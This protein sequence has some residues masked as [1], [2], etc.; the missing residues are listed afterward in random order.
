M[1]TAMLSV[2]IFICAPAYSA[3]DP[4]AKSVQQ[5]MDMARESVVVI[6]Q[7]ARDG[8]RE[9]IGTGFVISE[10]G[11]VA[12]SLHVIG[13]ARPIT[14]TFADGKTAAVTQVHAWDRKLDLA[15]IR[16][17]ATE[18]RAL[19]LGDSDKLKQG[20]SV[21]A[22]GNPQGL[23]HSVVQGVVS[24]LRE[25]EFGPMIQMAIPIEPGNSGGP[26]LDMKGRVQGILDM[27]SAVTEN[28]G[29]AIPINALKPLLEH[30][31]TV[32][33]E[34]WLAL[35][36]LNE[37]LWKPVMGAQWRRKAG[38]I[39]VE[40]AGSGFGGRSLCISQKAVPEAPY[41]I[42]VTVRLDDEAGAA[43]LAFGWDRG[44]RHYGFY[45][46]AGQLRLTRFDGP[47]VFTWNI[48]RQIETPHYHPGEW[49][50]LKVRVETEKILCFV[51]GHLVAEVEEE[52]G[53][54][55][56]GLAKFRNTSAQFKNFVLGQNVSSGKT[57]T[58]ENAELRKRLE[59]VVADQRPVPEEMLK[60]PAGG[61]TLLLT[62]ARDLDQRATTARK[63]ASELNQKA[64][65]RELLRIFQPAEPEVDLFAA[66]FAIARVEAPELELSGYRDEIDTL[67][68]EVEKRLGA[69]PSQREKLD[70]LRK[71]L[72]EESGYHGSRSDYYN[73][74]NSFMNR[75]M[76]DREGIPITL[77]V[78][79]LELGRK[80]GIEKLEGMPFPGH[81]MVRFSETDQEPLYVDVFDGGKMYQRNELY[82]LIGRHSEVPLLDEHF[83]P[84]TK[85]EIIVRMLRNLIGFPSESYARVLPYADLLLA[86]S[87]DDAQE[88]LRRA[89]WRWQAGERVRARE[90]LEWIMEHKPR[91]IDLERVAELY[92][93]LK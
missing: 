46:S 62:M 29:F 44:D 76:E 53:S 59:T 89:S 31:N 10:D 34:K 3:E 45:P 80:L 91:G 24:A 55:P 17:A 57:T 81:F 92:H 35:G 7:T 13:E 16:V 1:V 36:A 25:F 4:A 90:D 75:V 23:T 43:G 56:A 58:T 19:H 26:L 68:Q 93:N 48:L 74:A 67:A 87:P 70:G 11:L 65:E 2:L 41:E 9:A 6:K 54:G 30:P 51:N 12:T 14:V 71:F 60:D 37:G 50:N 77:S 32:P 47:T 15:V 63:L 78:L 66:A 33:F 20:T 22:I 83:K 40:G 84:A 5:L 39:T 28:L 21:V 64:V 73:R 86:L 49:N 18:I 27:K 42:A 88:R 8:V 69:N 52:A 85:R 61:R 72:F 82:D 79:F 38:M